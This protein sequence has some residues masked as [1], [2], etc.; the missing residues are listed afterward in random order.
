MGIGERLDISCR[1]KW[2]DN[3][4]FGRRGSGVYFKEGMGS[5]GQPLNTAKDNDRWVHKP[6]SFSLRAR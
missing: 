4:G 1:N 3:G 2:E 6:N 5:Y